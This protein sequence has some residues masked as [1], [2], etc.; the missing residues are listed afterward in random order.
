MDLQGSYTFDGHAS[1]VWALLMDP[2]SIASCVPGCE[3]LEPI[4]EDR[5]RTVLN[6]GVGAI[7][8][9]YEGTVAILDKEPTTAYRLVVDG[10]GRGGFVKGDARITLLDRGPTT[11]V[12]VAG[13]AQVGGL[14]ASVGQRLLG[15]V[16]KMML[17]KFFACMN[18]KLGKTS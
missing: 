9:T 2:A 12:T 5:Y 7:T 16:S 10:T 11:L 1:D 17:D 6:A 18:A 4:G 13:T 3:S 14:I 8:G 15:S